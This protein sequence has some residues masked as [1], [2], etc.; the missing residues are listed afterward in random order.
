LF[1]LFVEAGTVQ[2]PKSMEEDKYSFYR[3]KKEWQRHKKVLKNLPVVVVVTVVVVVVV[4]VVVVVVVGI[5]AAKN[6]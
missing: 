4:G 6:K 3:L 2:T 5:G 1:Y